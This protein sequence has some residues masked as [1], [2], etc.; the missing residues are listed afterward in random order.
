[1]KVIIAGGGKVGFYLAS[2]LIERNHRVSLIER[3]GAR[4][5]ALAE[6]LPQAL[7]ILG[8]AT[9]V[10]T[11]SDA[12]ADAGDTLAAV[13]GLD[14]ENLVICQLAKRRFALN[15]VIARASNPKNQRVLR[16]LGVD[17]VVSST[18]IIADLI[19][20]EM[21]Q[22]TIKTLLTFHHGDMTLLEVD[23]HGEAPSV[24]RRVSEL[25]RHLPKDC[26]LTTLIRGDRVIFPRGDTVLQ[27][28]DAVLAVTT[29][30]SEPELRATLLGG[31]RRRR[32][33]GA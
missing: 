14:E 6:R 22:E 24:G 32:P 21:A 33:G 12:G 10:A 11:L 19:E 5:Q 20:R 1:M 3:D 28:H 18:G 9:D 29:H 8:D 2:L 27:A 31:L 13:T 26:V 4:C 30:E 23:L 16:E 17:S 15:R 7:V 25:A